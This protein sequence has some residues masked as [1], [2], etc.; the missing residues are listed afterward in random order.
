MKCL[1]L[2]AFVFCLFAEN[3][4]SQNSLNV[5]IPFCQVNYSNANDQNKPVI[6]TP[7]SAELNGIKDNGIYWLFN[8][9]ALVQSMLVKDRLNQSYTG[10]VVHGR[11]GMMLFPHSQGIALDVFLRENGYFGTGITCFRVIEP[12]G[13]HFKFIP[14]LSAGRL[15]KEN[16]RDMPNHNGIYAALEMDITIYFTRTTGINLKPYTYFHFAEGYLGKQVGVRLGIG[17]NELD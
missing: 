8:A 14:Q 5:Y 17:F 2:S 13:N 7:Y 16:S 6:T 4:R 12:N 3:A 9:D 11:I 15:N 1:V 10:D